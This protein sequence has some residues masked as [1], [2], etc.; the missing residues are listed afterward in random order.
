MTRHRAVE[1]SAARRRER[2]ARRRDDAVHR[3]C[4]D[5][6]S[7]HD[8][9]QPGARRSGGRA[10]GGDA[11]ARRDVDAA[12]PR[13]ASRT[14]SA[15]RLLH[16]PLRHRARAWRAADRGRRFRPRGRAAAVA[17]E[18]ISRRHGDFALAGVAA[19]VDTRRRR[20][21][22]RRARIALLSVGR[23]ARCSPSRRRRLLV[24]QRPTAGS[25][26]ARPP[27]RPP[28]TTSIRRATS[29]RRARYRRQLAAVLTR[30]VARARRSHCWSQHADRDEAPS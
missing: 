9:R 10:A 7:R 12:Q 20:P 28:H 14:V 6:H 26:S 25:D 13:A 4:G 19:R 30:R 11:G 8:R 29:T 21:L 23:S 16:R 18:E 22:R 3:A 1:R 2:A 5:P 17:F 27:T 15:R 24:G